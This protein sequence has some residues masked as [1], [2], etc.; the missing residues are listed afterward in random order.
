MDPLVLLRLVRL[1]RLMGV[2]RRFSA[3]LF[4]LLQDH[5]RKILTE[6]PT[7]LSDDVRYLTTGAGSI[8]Q[9]TLITSAI[10]IK[11]EASTP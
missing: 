6:R 5:S 1:R 4:K 7:V 2:H 8:R 10:T 11:A 3:L 9:K